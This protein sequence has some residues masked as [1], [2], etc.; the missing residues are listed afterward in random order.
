MKRE[1]HDLS[2]KDDGDEKPSTDWVE[3]SE[4][5]AYL[6]GRVV[7]LTLQGNSPSVR[8]DGFREYYRGD[9]LHIGLV[10]LNLDRENLIRQIENKQI[11]TGDVL[12]IER[13]ACDSD[14][15]DSF[16]VLTSTEFVSR[17][18]DGEAGTSPA[19]TI[20]DLL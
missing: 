12:A 9:E 1:Q 7:D 11:S 13:V 16:Q 14:E 5:G 17:M 20:K 8:V 15:E 19:K 3:Q 2:V 10:Y 4:P 6:V 18:Y